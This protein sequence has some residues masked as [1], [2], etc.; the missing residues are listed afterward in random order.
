M[1]TLRIDE[2]FLNAFKLV[3]PLPAK[4]I[5]PSLSIAQYRPPKLPAET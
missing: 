1:I 3:S 2:L 4:V 5:T